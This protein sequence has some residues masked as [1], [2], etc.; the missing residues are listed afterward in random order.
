[1]RKNNG[2]EWLKSPNEEWL[3]P[4]FLVYDEE[5]NYILKKQKMKIIPYGNISKNAMLH[6]DDHEVVYKKIVK[7]ELHEDPYISE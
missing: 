6:N 4:K 7:D 5:D 1:M 3:K 2:E